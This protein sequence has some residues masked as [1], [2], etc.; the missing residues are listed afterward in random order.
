MIRP[1]MMADRQ[2]HQLES[3]IGAA[4]V[5]DRMLLVLDGELDYDRLTNRMVTFFAGLPAGSPMLDAAFSVMPAGMLQ[6][7]DPDTTTTVQ[8]YF[9]PDDFSLTTYNDLASADVSSTST[10]LRRM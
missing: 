4:H 5:T 7:A 9:L 2:V 10:P 1:E 6:T 3:K 8:A